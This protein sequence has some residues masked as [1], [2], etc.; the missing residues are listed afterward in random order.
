MWF[1]Q[2]NYWHGCIKLNKAYFRSNGS[3]YWKVRQF[4]E[5]VCLMC[6]QN[7]VQQFLV[8]LN[9]HQDASLRFLSFRLDFNEHY[10]ARDSRL[11]TPQPLQKAKRRTWNRKTDWCCENFERYWINWTIRVWR[12]PLSFREVQDKGEI[13]CPYQLEKLMDSTVHSHKAMSG[14]FCLSTL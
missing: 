5:N 13:D 14:S 8:M 4:H 11:R 6:L 2:V 7:M 3:I 12:T 10:K 1:G 9:G